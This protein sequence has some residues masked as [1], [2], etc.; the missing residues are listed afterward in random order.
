MNEILTTDFLFYILVGFV[1]QT[2]DGTLGMG[3]GISSSTMLLA[4]GVPPA[5]SSAIV[6][7]A[8]CF[9][10]GASALSHRAFGNFDA[11]LVRKLLIP[12]VLGAMIGVSVLVYFPGDVIKPYISIYLL[13][14]GITILIKTF[15]PIQPKQV[16]RNIAPLGFFGALVDAIGGGGWGSIVTSNLVARGNNVAKTIGSVN[17][18]EFFVTLT[19]SILFL[20]TIGL[21]HWHIVLGLALGGVIAAPLGAWLAGRIPTVPFMRLTSLAVT[22]IAVRSLA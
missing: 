20:L 7:T 16:T 9:T 11:A 6:H 1:A 4:F 15:R 22:L 17:F 18:V 8:E 10:T 21:T 3:Y 13:L 2:I 5:T 19:S 12:G 14:M